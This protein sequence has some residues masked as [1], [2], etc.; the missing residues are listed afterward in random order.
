MFYGVLDGISAEATPEPR[1]AARSLSP[2]PHDSDSVA[3]FLES[4]RMQL[5]GLTLMHFLRV[6][7]GE[8][9]FHVEGGGGGD[10]SGG[11]YVLRRGRAVVDWLDGMGAD[12]HP[13]VDIAPRDSEPW[14]LTAQSLLDER[15][16]PGARHVPGSAQ[17]MR[18]V[19][20]DAQLALSPSGEL[21]VLPLSGLDQAYQEEVLGGVWALVRQGRVKEAQVHCI[22]HRMFWLS[23][24]IAGVLDFYYEA[25]P[26]DAGAAHSARE[27][28]R[29]NMRRP[30]FLRL[31]YAYADKMRAGGAGPVGQAA[32]SAGRCRV[33]EM[34]IYAALGL[35]LPV[36]LG[37]PLLQGA[38][39]ELW[40]VMKV[41]PFKQSSL[42]QL[43]LCPASHLP[44][45]NHS[46]PMPL[47]LRS[48]F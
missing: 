36:L 10:G 3:C 5:P 47:R 15:L 25:A 43:S 23:A 42:P 37:S 31:A 34:T 24:S 28:R 11:V 44:S 41:S 21:V 35:N 46:P 7:L 22:K 30:V 32:E 40:A 20:P 26:R 12:S 45:S 39:D 9:R 6:A 29:G 2:S 1:T 19:H 14:S 17:G 13:F 4:A 16:V 18:S 48:S 8:E 33:L 38:E 27:V